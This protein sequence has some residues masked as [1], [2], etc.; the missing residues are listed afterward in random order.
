[1]LSLSSI[2]G[3]LIPV[4][5]TVDDR[6]V[7]TIEGAMNNEDRAWKYRPIQCF[8]VS[9]YHKQNRGKSAVALVGYILQQTNERTTQECNEH[10][11]MMARTVLLP[12]LHHK[13]EN[14]QSNSIINEE[15]AIVVRR[16]STWNSAIILM[17]STEH[18]YKIPALCVRAAALPPLIYFPPLQLKCSAME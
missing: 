11:M 13:T 3:W 5:Y 18:E 8:C 10:P 4:D 6:S 12:P 7:S 2:L 14:F 17:Y 9:N 16:A 15:K 1:M